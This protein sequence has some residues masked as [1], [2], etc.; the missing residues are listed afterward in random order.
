MDHQR[1]EEMNIPDLY[2]TG[3]LSAGDEE[4][5]ETHLL[6]CRECRDQVAWADDFRASVRTVAVEETAHATVRTGLLVWLA[7]RS[8]AVRLGLTA[9]LIVLAGLP[10]WLLGE[11]SRLLGELAEARAAAARPAVQTVPASQGPDAATKVAM[12]RL[13]QLAQDRTRLEGELAREREA[14]ETLAG[15]LAG[16]TRPQGNTALFSLGVVRGSSD[17]GEVVLGPRPEFIV[18]SLELPAAE[19]E[20]YRATLYD[21][22]GRQVWRQGDL[23][24]TSSD[25]LP[26]L[27]HSDFLKPGKY[28]VSLEGVDEGRAVPAGKLP[29]QVRRQG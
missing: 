11:Q 12:D 20:T 14:G 22:R 27:V 28:Q 13:V 1:I 18:L 17:S 29:F 9:A 7:R 4:A 6:E 26:V 8:H 15:R 21:A 2:A 24:P 23:V 5:F 10:A 19:F 16:L 3:R 25:T